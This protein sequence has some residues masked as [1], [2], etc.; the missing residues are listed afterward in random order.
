[1]NISL[2]NAESVLGPLCR[3]YVCAAFDVLKLQVLS[4]SG[5]HVTHLIWAVGVLSN[6]RPHYL[7]TWHV[8]GA[9][10]AGWRAIA[11]DLRA[12]GVERLRIVI[13]PDPVE[14]QA[15]M[16]PHYRDASVLPAS[17]PIAHPEL[18]ST[19]SG[20]R[21]YVERALEVTDS[22]ALRLKRAAARHGPFADAAAAAALLRRS[23]EH[24]VS[25]DWPES[26]E[27]V[28]ALRSPTVMALSATA[29]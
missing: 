10:D 25:R 13:G 21:Q 7:G 28:R 29:S 5:L 4:D 22:L 8:Q 19:L 15:A 12:R 9:N 23:A 24:C 1:M 18:A 27:P 26:L 3:S 11:G 2:T 14:M 17:T 6:H 16:T 20:H